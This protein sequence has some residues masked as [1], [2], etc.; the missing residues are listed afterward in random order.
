M[1]LITT[2]DGPDFRDHT[3]DGITAV[4]TGNKLRRVKI[5]Y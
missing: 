3:L 2:E 5:S 1:E 4:I